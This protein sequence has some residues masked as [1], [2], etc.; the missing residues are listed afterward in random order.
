MEAIKFCRNCGK[1]NQAYFDF[2]C[3]C[4]Q[5]FNSDTAKKAP[6]AVVEEEEPKLNAEKQSPEPIIEKK[7]SEQAAKQETT[8]PAAERK[9]SKPPKESSKWPKKQKKD[10][11]KSAV[12]KDPKAEENISA[13]TA[14]GFFNS[15]ESILGKFAY[16]EGC[17]AYAKIVSISNDRV[18]CE[19]ID[20]LSTF[21]VKQSFVKMP[22]GRQA[23]PGDYIWATLKELQFEHYGKNRYHAYV[24]SA[25]KNPKQSL[26]RK[27]YEDFCSNY[28]CGSGIRAPIEEVTDKYFLV[29]LSPSL[30]GICYRNTVPQNISYS[31]LHKGDVKQFVVSQFRPDKCSVVLGILDMMEQDYITL[32]RWQQLPDEISRKAKVFIPHKKINDLQ[33]DQDKYD[34]VVAELGPLYSVDILYPFLNEV[35]LRERAERKLTVK[36]DNTTYTMSFD[37][38]IRTK[39]GVPLSA[40]FKK[41][42][43]QDSWTMNLMGFTSATEIFTRY[44]YVDDLKQKLTDLEGIALGGEQ[45]DFGNAEKGSK[46]I[47]SNYLKFSFYKSHLDGLIV[48]NDQGDAVFNTGLVDSIY[49]DV[50]CFL[51]KN[52]HTNDFLK[53]QW[54]LGYFACWGKK[55][56]G[57]RLNICFSE[58]PTA[59]QYIDPNKLQDIYYDVTK[60]LFCDYNHIIEDNLERLPIGFVLNSLPR[61]ADND[62]LI[63]QYRKTHS[64]QDFET[65]KNAIIKNESN[66]RRVADDLKK[67]VE[68]AQKY[69]KWNYKTA[70]PTYYPRTNSIN[71]LLPLYLSEDKT[72]ADV[73]LVVERLDNGNYQGQTILT[74]QMAYQN[75]R[76]ICRPNSEWLTV[77][78]IGVASEEI[79][80]ELED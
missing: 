71:L 78:Q 54:E 80:E 2:C 40:A 65:I 22:D 72:K 79:D 13:N 21:S 5:P 66:L 11:T 4:G 59:P 52:T 32:K 55:Q 14:A 75:S 31:L 28:P 67:A 9:S 19:C 1:L 49:D 74:L 70:I 3:Q 53:R 47:L 42:K 60:P 64:K 76:Q 58:R 57:K 27:D 10:E 25:Q 29:R 56:D 20:R 45:W 24:V 35:Y 18:Y 69:C 46:S 38:G 6:D 61:G 62:A 30:T 51:R 16:K 37:T 43:G 26:R 7:V 73:A 50:Y 77:N 63:A 15:R 68:T 48:G 17:A 36:E 34:A 39:K 44:V 33:E 12:E 8:K 23:V 41:T